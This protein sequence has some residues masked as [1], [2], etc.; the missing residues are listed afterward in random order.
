MKR[1]ATPTVTDMAARFSSKMPAGL[2]ALS[3]LSAAAWRR[4]PPRRHAARV[5]VYGRNFETN[6][7][8]QKGPRDAA[9][10]K[11]AGRHLK[12]IIL[13]CR[14]GGCDPD[15]NR[16]LDKAIKK[17]V[18]DN[19]PKK[20]IEGRIKKYQEGGESIIEFRM[21]GYGVGGAAIM[22]DCVCDN[23][24]RARTAVNGAFKECGGEVGN[25]GSVAHMFKKQG[26][27]TFEGADEEKI[28][29]AGMEM[30][31]EDCA[32]NEE[33]AVEVTTEPEHFIA[34][35]EAYE[36]MGMEPSSSKIGEFAT[37]PTPL[38]EGKAYEVLRLLWALQELD[39]V[40]NVHTT[41]ELPDDLELKFNTY[42][43]PHTWEWLQKNP[44][45]T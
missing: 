31:I 11:I 19:V 17:A 10:N 15:I 35:V 16:A 21:E 39:D 1:G 45:R 20:T 34:T 18:K 24:T 37:I 9:N 7:K 25:N 44:G 4:A 27:L 3:L 12:D 2:I 28:M 33:G 6:I 43:Q 36:S 42:G 8:K 32:T 40:Q 23:K 22:V 5:I 38:D 14:D 29:E 41:A 30:E 13:C 26:L